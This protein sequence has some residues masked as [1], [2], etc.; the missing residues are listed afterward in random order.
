[1]RLPSDMR[2]D[3]VGVTSTAGA[4]TFQNATIVPAFAANTR[5]RIWAVTVTMLESQTAMRRGYFT[6]VGGVAADA[7]GSFAVSSAALPWVQVLWPGGF[8]LDENT[9]L[10][11]RWTANAAAGQEVQ[12]VTLY[13][14]EAV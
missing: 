2:A 7:I 8:P 6:P 14:I 11:A 10:Q 13:T 12:F 1:M 5:L 9:G 4:G 3:Q